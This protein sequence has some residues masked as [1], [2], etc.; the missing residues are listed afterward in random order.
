MDLPGEVPVIADRGC[1]KGHRYGMVIHDGSPAWN[2]RAAMEAERVAKICP[3]CHPAP[4]LLARGS[5]GAIVQSHE[6]A[7]VVGPTA[8]GQQSS[9]WVWRPVPQVVP[10]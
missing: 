1:P 10:G 3:V 8:R 7:R 6:R 4:Y 9:L 5:G 2:Q